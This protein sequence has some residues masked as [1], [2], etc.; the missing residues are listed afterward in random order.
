M[1]NI[2]N[3]AF[4]WDLN[5]IGDTDNIENICNSAIQDRIL[6]K[7]E[8]QL[9]AWD[10]RNPGMK[11]IIPEIEIN[12]LCT[13]FS[14]ATIEHLLLRQFNYILEEKTKKGILEG[15]QESRNAVT[16]HKT[17]TVE[18]FLIQYLKKGYVQNASDAKEINECIR[19]SKLEKKNIRNILQIIAEDIEASRRFLNLSSDIEHSVILLFKNKDFHKNTAFISLF[20]EQLLKALFPQKDMTLQI[21]MW[22]TMLQSSS[23]IKRFLETLYA[24]LEPLII[25]T[26]QKSETIYS[27]SAIILQALCQFEIKQSINV[28]TIKENIYKLCMHNISSEQKDTIDTINS[29]RENTSEKTEVK[30]DKP[31]NPDQSVDKKEI[32]KEQLDVSVAENNFKHKETSLNKDNHSEEI[33]DILNQQYLK[34]TREFDSKKSLDTIAICARNVGLFILHPFLK[35][36]FKEAGILDGDVIIQPN[37]GVQLLNYL[38]TG[39]DQGKDISLTTE[40]IIVGIPVAQPVIITESLS[41]HDKLLCDELLKAVLKHWTVLE[42]SGIDTLRAMFLIRE[43]TIIL[44]EKNITIEAQHLAQDVLLNKLP[45]GLG[46]VLFPWIKGIFQIHWKS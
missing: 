20:L 34:N 15:S 28:N 44:K 41:K 21:Q 39:N 46:M 2:E 5:N 40:K 22:K 3:I 36:F 24:I 30:K 27:F 11:C 9:D 6:P 37:K 13:D 19:N 23:S 38:A 33:S 43:G 18:N 8:Q 12:I 29:K 31:N 4:N 25:F 1:H 45:W 7:I 26:E 10:S 16:L 32:R 35:E 42:K 14:I 17:A